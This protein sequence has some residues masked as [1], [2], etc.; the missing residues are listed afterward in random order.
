VVRKITNRK[1]LWSDQLANAIWKGKKKRI[2]STKKPIGENVFPDWGTKSI[3]LN[4]RT[5]N[6]REDNGRGLRPR[7]EKR[8]WGRR[9]MGESKRPF[10]H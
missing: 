9:I 5:L 1:Q 4:T 3:P 7:E 6:Q 10:D 2:E 8:T